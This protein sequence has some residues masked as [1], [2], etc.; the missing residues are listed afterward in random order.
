MGATEGQPTPA[1]ASNYVGI[2]DRR[3]LMNLTKCHLDEPLRKSRT[4][5]NLANPVSLQIH[6]PYTNHIPR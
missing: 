6:K 1:M 4:K 2:R 5:C 3:P